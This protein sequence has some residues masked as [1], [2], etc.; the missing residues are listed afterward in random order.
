MKSYATDIKSPLL[1]C[2]NGIRDNPA[3]DTESPH[4]LDYSILKNMTAKPHIAEEHMNVEVHMINKE[5]VGELSRYFKEKSNVARFPS[6]I[7]EKLQHSTWENIH[8]AIRYAKQGDERKARIHVDIASSACK[9]LAHF[10]NEAV[11][12]A[13]IID[14]EKH[15]DAVK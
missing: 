2:V 12:T 11:Y 3:G 9:E 15:L 14:I 6:G 4:I 7:E 10:M 1:E 5:N 13:F 8:A